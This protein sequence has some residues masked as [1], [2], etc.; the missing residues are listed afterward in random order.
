MNWIRKKI[1]DWILKDYIKCYPQKTIHELN[2]R[3]NI[4]LEN[5]YT[6]DIKLLKEVFMDGNQVAINELFRLFINRLLQD[7]YERRANEN[8]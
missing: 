7:Y 8:Q 4:Y 5:D 2:D 3:V 1:L 6:I